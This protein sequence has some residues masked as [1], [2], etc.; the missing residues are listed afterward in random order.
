MKFGKIGFKG[1]ETME[2]YETLVEYY[3]DT[4]KEK[5]SEELREFLL[6][7]ERM[8]NLNGRKVKFDECN[9]KSLKFTRVEYYS[10]AMDTV[11][12]KLI[13]FSQYELIKNTKPEAT[14]VLRS[15][16]FYTKIGGSFSTKLDSISDLEEDINDSNKYTKSLVPV[17]SAE[18]LDKKATE[19]LEYFYPDALKE[20]M[21]LPVTEMLN[22][23][24]IKWLKAPLDDNTSGKIYFARDIVDVYNSEYS[25]PFT[26]GKKNYIEQVEV[27]PATILINYDKVFENPPAMRN[28]L[29]HEAVHWFFHRN[30]FELKHF[31]NAEYTCMECYKAEN[32]YSDEEVW[33]MELQARRLAPRILMPYEPAKKKLEEII[34]ELNS[35]FRNKQITF[36]GAW[37]EVLKR[38]ANFFGVTLTSAK[39]RIHELGYYQIDGIFN[40][41]KGERQSD[42]A[43]R[44]GILKERQTFTISK[45]QL[46]RILQ[47]NEKLAKAFKDKKLAYTNGMVVANNTK[48]FDGDSL[49]EYA[50]AHP[51]ECCLIFNV[52]AEKNFIIDEHGEKVFL[53]SSKGS[54]NT[55]NIPDEYQALKVIGM[56]GINWTHFNAHAED[57]PKDLAGTIKYHYDKWVENGKALTPPEYRTNVTVAEDIGVTDLTF[58]K[59]KKDA[60]SVDRLKALKI[61]LAMELS[62][63]YLLDLIDKVDEHKVKLTE[64]NII[65]NTIVYG[66]AQNRVNIVAVYNSL[67][68]IGKEDVLKLNSTWVKNHADDII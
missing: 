30:Y 54:G 53:S 10:S 24:N 63:P 1:S 64:E 44:R 26:F 36:V 5:V 61:G 23:K 38:F 13:L 46:L 14:I 17:I 55:K 27:E 65:F 4:H 58:R 56:G 60:S 31:L 21:R 48:Y 8:I 7:R 62:T 9:I 12:F 3:Q 29:V 34:E 2:K 22:N 47:S 41:I 6:K 35:L 50:L 20:P 28:T 43:V 45:E 67:K 19:F 66:A 37:N 52:E 68:K 49:T 15:G 51:E 57:I 40:Y 42:Y 39:Y 32:M 18:Q 16:H 11:K 25:G 59:Y 33:W